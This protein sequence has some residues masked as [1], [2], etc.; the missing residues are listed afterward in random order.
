MTSKL[1]GQDSSSLSVPSVL[2]LGLPISVINMDI[3]VQTIIS[4]VTARKSNYICIRDVHGVMLSHEDAELMRIHQAAGMVTPDG[5]PIVWAARHRSGHDVE[6]VCGSDLVEALCGSGRCSGL[7]HFFYGGKP[8]TAE[9]VISNLQAQ[10]K[11]ISIAGSYSPPFHQLT[12][13]E[14]AAVV[15]RINESGANIVWVGLSTPK[16]EVWMRDHVNELR[17]ATL[18][19]VGAAFD[20][21]AGVVKRA[22]K[23]M[24]KS[25]FEW[26]H[27]LLSEPRRL[28]R[29]YLVIAPKFV[30][31]YLGEELSLWL[32]SKMGRLGHGQRDPGSKLATRI[33]SS[34]TCGAD[35]PR[36]DQ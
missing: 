5:M 22:P 12:A 14:D 1:D 33:L 24:Q 17:G 36:A 21:H 4:W 11:G 18:I 6:R 13:D 10:F 31:T 7:S 25:G 30:I 20:F 28:W 34:T 27:R 26:L 29:R 9:K 35:T 3:A 32:H 16:Q 2:I 8:G 15:K 19:G 23:W